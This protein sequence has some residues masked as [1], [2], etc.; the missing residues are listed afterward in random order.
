MC[1]VSPTGF[2]D[3]SGIRLFM[4]FLSLVALGVAK[5]A[6]ARS[7]LL[8][9]ALV[10][11]ST[12]VAV[13]ERGAIISSS[14]SGVSWKSLPSPTKETLTGVSFADDQVGWVVG[15]GGTV[16]ATTGGG[17][18]W[19]RQLLTESVD[20]SFLDVLALDARTAIA[21]GA[22]GTTRLT[23]DGGQTWAAP[24]PIDQEPHLNRIVQDLR[25]ALWIAGEA[26]TLLTSSDRGES[27]SPAETVGYEGSLYGLLPLPEGG[28]LVH[29]LRGHLF[30]REKQRGS[31]QASQ[32]EQP[33]MLAASCRL[34]TG[35]ILMAG[36]AR[37]F[38]ISH[39]Q[40]RSF[41]RLPLPVTSA[42]AELLEMPDGGILAL[43]EA[44]AIR[45][46]IPTS[47]PPGSSAR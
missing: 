20:T 14:D 36:A 43:G 16:L 18:T 26:G 45:L 23:R 24:T 25:G 17:Q 28:L 1:R 37:W 40:G 32:V 4:V 39:D 29:G 3:D 19:T 10:G 44:G 27:W 15:H 22:F 42:V 13:G 33:V 21:I 7:L 41:S 46:E 5:P 38:F 35:V 6:P 12:V 11:G 31:W 9:G 8:D 2:R 30:L 34:R 47:S